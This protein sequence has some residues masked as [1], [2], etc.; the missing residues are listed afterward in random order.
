MKMS[1]F[2]VVAIANSGR[3]CLLCSIMVDFIRSTLEV[4]YDNLRAIAF[5]SALQARLPHSASDLKVYGNLR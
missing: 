5:P 4:I 1:V 3:L 2:S